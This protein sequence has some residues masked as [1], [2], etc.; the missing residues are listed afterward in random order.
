MKQKFYWTEEKVFELKNIW[1]TKSL[2]KIAADFHTTEETIREK[3][4]EIG[5]EEYKSNR[6]TKEEEQLLREYSKKYVTKTIAKK[7]G[8]SY[9]A[10]QKKAVKLGIELHSTPDPWKKWMIDYLKDNINKQPIGQIESMIGLSYHSIV[11]KCKELGIEY[12]KESWTEEEIKI[13][14][15]YADKCHYTELTKVLPNRTI[16]AISAKAYELGIET[17]STYTKLDD[18]QIKYIKDNWGEIPATEI[19]RNLKISIGILNRY[20]KE[21]NLPNTGQQKKW[22]EDKISKLRKDAKTKTRNELAKK[23]KSS[24]A[25]ISTI[26]RKNNIK[27][28]DSKIVWTDELVSQLEKLIDQ[29]LGI[30]EISKEMDMKAY[31]IRQ[32]IRK[33]K[34]DDFVNSSSKVMRWTDDEVN[35]LI[36]LSK[37]YTTEEIAEMLNKTER[38]VYNKAVK[39]GIQINRNKEKLWTEKDTQTLINLHDSY[40]LHL[41]SK[42]MGRSE[43]VIREKAKVLG[44]KL[45][46]KERTSWSLAEEQL[47]REYAKD[48]TINEIAYLLERTTSSVNAKLRYMGIKAV[49]SSKFWTEEE[50]SELKRLS[51][52]FSIEEIAEKMNKSYDSIIAK[53]YQ[54]GIRAKNYSNKRWT[55]E[56]ELE[57]LELLT[58][59]SSFEVAEILERSEEA[60]IVKAINLGYNIDSKHRN[61]T[62]EEETLLSDLWGSES[63]ENIAK[64]L[65]RTVSSITN[66]V[67]VLGLGSQI[68]NNYDGLRIQDI[69]DIF[70]VNRNV[71]LTSWVSLGLK[72]SFRKRS[73]HSV[74][75]YVQIN[76]LYEFLE[77]NQNIWDSR[78]L[79]K[80]ILGAEPEWLKEKRIRDRLLP[81]GEFGIEN[82]TKQQ[83]LLA[84]QYFLNSEQAKE[85]TEPSENA[86]GP[87]LVKTKDNKKR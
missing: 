66:R 34:G 43:A 27:L 5:L 15:E 70:Q 3:A 76:N 31:S 68:E 73:N 22:T 87:R 62:K 2:Y 13:L 28:I 85:T 20:K 4:S 19:A 26:A 6:W 80:N 82:L 17:I 75:S 12:V 36:S 74:Y 61:W 77:E 52:N 81:A 39:L 54:L 10:V 41:I 48:Y 63:I 24:P 33:M 38:Q 78:N 64:K 42:V 7:L 29:G 83:L 50:E 25:Q 69:S 55:K 46:F 45:K 40:E 35:K 47:L 67:Y 8:R 23:Y 44:L 58:S 59:Y 49:Q 21:L 56:E 72:L 57:L 79:E 1:N 60:I 65:N 84:K 86:T 71:I 18:K 14:R 16:G 51:D 37:T 9:L 30:S 11:A 32:Q 53:L